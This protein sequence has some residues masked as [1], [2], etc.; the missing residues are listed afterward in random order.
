MKNTTEEALV[1]FN[2]LI[3]NPGK[4]YNFEMWDGKKYEI[5]TLSGFTGTHSSNKVEV[6]VETDM[7]IETIDL[8]KVKAII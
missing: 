3:T 7:G 8:Y 5:L 6:T 2:L 1:F 4:I